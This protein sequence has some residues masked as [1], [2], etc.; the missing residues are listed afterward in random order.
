MQ[1]LTRFILG[2]WLTLSLTTLNIVAA[3]PPLVGGPVTEDRYQVIG[4]ERDDTLNIRARPDPAAPIVGGIPADGTGIRWLGP[5]KQHGRST[6]REIEYQGLR[7]WVNTRFLTVARAASADEG[8]LDADLHCLGTEPFWRISIRGSRMELD[9]M[10]DKSQFTAAA[11]RV[12]ANHTNVWAVT[13]EN[14][15]RGERGTAFLER[16]GRCSDDMS[17]HQYQYTFRVM[18]GDDVVWSGCCDR[19]P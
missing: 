5:A 15:T 11:P 19:I 8:G 14:P 12:S 7:G 18:I 3:E 16:T 6:W 17:D 2:A 9:Q 1:S 4:V 13:F 10:G